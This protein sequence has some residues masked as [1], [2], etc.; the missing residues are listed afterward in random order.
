MSGEG[1]LLDE[2]QLR[3]RSVDLLVARQDLMDLKARYF[4]LLDTKQWIGWA[5]LFTEDCT[6]WVEDQPDVTYSDRDSFVGTI[7]DLLENAVTVHQGH[8]P[9]F[10]FDQ[11]SGPPVS[12][13]GIWA[14]SDLIEIPSS[15]SPVV[16]RGYGHYH[17]TYRRELGEQWR[18][19][20]L[21]LY[22]LRI[23]WGS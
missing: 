10:E 5:Q 19:S 17:E 12:A 11:L 2:D 4:R 3:D 9:E 22:R 6:M 18:I 14:M 20:S 15:E 1:S 21:R 7:R 8:M 13:R 23:D 16:L